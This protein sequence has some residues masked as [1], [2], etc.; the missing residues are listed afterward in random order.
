[1]TE[2]GARIPQLFRKLGG[3]RRGALIVWGARSGPGFRAWWSPTS[4]EW[5]W[6]IRDV[7]RI[8]SA[9]D[10]EAAARRIEK[11]VS[12]ASEAM[13]RK[14]RKE[15]EMKFGEAID[16]LKAGKLVARK[17]WNGK[18]MHLYLDEGLVIPYGGS[19]TGQACTYEPCIVMFTAQKKHQPGWL[20]SQADMLAAD[21]V[22]VKPTRG[23]QSRRRLGR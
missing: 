22:I 15:S 3:R 23:A 2:R 6:R 8:G 9:E 4:R 12:L 21:W 16:A 18:R 1:M 11:T 17:G 7:M 20:A 19:W 10:P 5:Y 13:N 14:Y